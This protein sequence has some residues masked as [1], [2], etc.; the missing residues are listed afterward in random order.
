M[1]AKEPP[2]TARQPSRQQRIYD[3]V[4]RVPEGQVASYGQLARLVG[5]GARLVGY[6]MA[7]LPARSEVPWHRV[8]NADGGIS[9]R[10]SGGGEIRQRRLLEAEGVRFDSRGRVDL[11]TVGWHGPGWDW[12]ERHGYDPGAL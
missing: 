2:A 8:I 5:C 9:P 3:L 10:R 11:E 1:S 6:A 12:L 4:R 7:A